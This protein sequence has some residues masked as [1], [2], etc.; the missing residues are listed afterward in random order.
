M[1]NNHIGL[2]ILFIYLPILNYDQEKYKQT[3]KQK[4]INLIN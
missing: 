4:E 2:E 1:H 3:L